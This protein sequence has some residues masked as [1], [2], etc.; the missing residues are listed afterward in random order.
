MV[1]LLAEPLR[2][3]GKVELA[4]GTLMPVPLELVVFRS[5]VVSEKQLFCQISAKSDPTVH[6]ISLTSG[7]DTPTTLS[8]LDYPKPC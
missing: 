4:R 5:A 3:G 8:C 2:I 6:S 1:G 7:V